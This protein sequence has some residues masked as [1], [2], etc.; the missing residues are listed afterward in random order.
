MPE[1]IILNFGVKFHFNI[2]KKWLKFQ[3]HNFWSLEI[4]EVVDNFKVLIVDVCNK[5][6]GEGLKRMKARKQEI[7]D[8]I[9]SREDAITDTNTKGIF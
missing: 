6:E 4:Q 1:F 3:N 5:M 7:D 9:Q 8:L 2:I